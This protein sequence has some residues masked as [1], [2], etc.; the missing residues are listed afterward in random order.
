MEDDKEYISELFKVGT[1]IIGLAAALGVFYWLALTPKIT[2]A[3]QQ[4]PIADPPIEEWPPTEAG[5]PP[6]ID[7][8]CR[9]AEECP[10]YVPPS[11][12]P[13]DMGGSERP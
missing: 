13:E 5:S 7:E 11:E 10:D 8:P 2:S 12:E 9:P 6:V 1:S 3:P 4:P